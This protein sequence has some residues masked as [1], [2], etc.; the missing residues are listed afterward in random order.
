MN[1]AGYGA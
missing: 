1:D